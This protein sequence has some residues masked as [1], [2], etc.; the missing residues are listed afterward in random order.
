MWTTSTPVHRDE[1]ISDQ[2]RQREEEVFGAT[3]LHKQIATLQTNCS[4][5]ENQV[6]ELVKSRDD[7][8]LLERRVRKGLY[9]LASGRMKIEE[10]LKVSVF[11]YIYELH[12]I[13]TVGI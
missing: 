8:I 6:K 11:D 9:R 13:D 7:A 3:S 5:L 2:Q 4:K 1:D 10:V 12:F